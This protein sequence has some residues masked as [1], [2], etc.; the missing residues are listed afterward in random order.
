MPSI[1]N[2]TKCNQ[3]V[4]IK[5]T[6]TVNQKYCQ[7]PSTKTLKM[8]IDRTKLQTVGEKLWYLLLEQ[9]HKT[10][11]LIL[12]IQVEVIFTIAQVLTGW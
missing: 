10:N 12:H 2:L 3:K 6:N 8:R 7:K 9:E 1:C 5:K 4:K 11:I